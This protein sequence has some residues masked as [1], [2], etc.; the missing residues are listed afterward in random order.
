MWLTGCQAGWLR[1]QQPSVKQYLPAEADN[2]CCGIGMGW[3]FKYSQKGAFIRAPSVTL[4]LQQQWSNK[5]KVSKEVI[6]RM[7]E[8]IHLLFWFTNRASQP[9]SFKHFQNF[10]TEQE[11]VSNLSIWKNKH[12]WTNTHANVRC[13]FRTTFP[14]C[15]PIILIIWIVILGSKDFPFELLLKIHILI[16][17]KWIHPTVGLLHT[18]Q[19][20]PV[21]PVIAL[22]EPD[23]SP[24]VPST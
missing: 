18:C 8:I 21:L 6:Q 23:I 2:N 19:V 4:G 10:H 17:F 7:T 12:L 13:P 5:T 16:W 1:Q 15:T 9:S 24:A 20:F 3:N 22:A 14:T 11:L